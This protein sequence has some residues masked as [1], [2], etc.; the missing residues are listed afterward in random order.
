VKVLHIS[1]YYG[2]N[3]SGAPVAALRLHNALLRNNVDSHFLCID[4]RSKGDNVHV[5][6]VSKLK[7]RIFYLFVRGVWVFSRIVF[8]RIF[9]FNLFPLPDFAAAV[10]RINPDII[11]IHL[12]SQDMVSFT[13]L[14]ALGIPMVFTLHDL[15]IVNAADPY[16]G[17][18][19]RFLEGFNKENSSAIERWL[20][21]RKK[22][23]VD[24]CR[25][26]FTG[27]S[28]WVCSA[29][30][31]SIIGRNSRV[32]LVPNILNPIFGYNPNICEKH[33]KFTILFGAFNG[34]KSPLKGWSDLVEVLKILPEEVRSSIEVCVFGENGREYCEN[35]VRVWF[36]GVID[37]PSVLQNLHHRVDVF[38]LP[39]KQDNAPQVKFEALI[40]GLPVI[41]FDR[42][43]CAEYLE[44]GVNG[45]VAPDGDYRE[46][47][48]GIEHFRN[49]FVC[50]KLQELR[51]QIADKTKSKFSEENIVGQYLKIYGNCCNS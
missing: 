8:G 47:A 17:D 49:L 40:D 15:M 1:Y 43:G 20:W 42:T 27:P 11:H 37:E 34:R 28:K 22:K 39:S 31:N 25:P 36:A 3:I 32:F 35:G 46:Y 19:I 50:G 12:I 44:N 30:Q 29:F 33:S 13:Q 48:K 41:A 21:Q 14:E 16:P 5:V 23:F 38:A 4:S 18:D 2:N 9:M 6:P 26:F 10:K 51:Q 45:W 7:R 24:K